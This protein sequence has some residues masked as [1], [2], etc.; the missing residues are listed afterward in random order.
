MQIK[1]IIFINYKPQDVNIVEIRENQ[2]NQ[3]DTQIRERILKEMD[4]S[5]ENLPVC[6]MV[7]VRMSLDLGIALENACPYMRDCDDK[8]YRLCVE[9]SYR[10]CPFYTARVASEI[11][12]GQLDLTSIS[13]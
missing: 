11:I 6:A 12:T 1:T 2:R 9:N 3:I 7:S 8:D 4:E 10:E 13:V 5:P